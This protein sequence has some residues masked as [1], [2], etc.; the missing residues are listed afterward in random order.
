MKLTLFFCTILLFVFAGI[1]SAS[2]QGFPYQDFKPRTLREI[3][4]LEKDVEEAKY[5]KPQIVFHGDLLLSVVRVVYTG[6]SRQINKTKSEMLA[7]WSKM[8]TGEKEDYAQ[9]YQTDLLFTEDGKE[10]W[11]PVQKQVI[12]YFAKELKKG[13]VVDLYLVRAGGLHLKDSWDWM[14]LVEEFNKPQT[15]SSN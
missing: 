15:N 2:A 5:D 14:L 4:A 1:S 11:L 7:N 10:Y 3:A 13:D 8:Y 6:E 12:P 9:L